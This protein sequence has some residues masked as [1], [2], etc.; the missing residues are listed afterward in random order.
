MKKMTID[1]GQKQYLMIRDKCGFKEEPHVLHGI[2]SQI[3]VN[4]ANNF[5]TNDIIKIVN[6]L[7]KYQHYLENN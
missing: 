2:L 1:A 5:E 7:K 4:W 3:P 6:M